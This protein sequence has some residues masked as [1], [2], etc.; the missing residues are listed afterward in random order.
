MVEGYLC[1]FLTGAF[2]TTLAPA[3]A[4]RFVV[5][6]ATAASTAARTRTKMPDLLYLMDL[7]LFFEQ[8]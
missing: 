5:D 6:V 3:P 1:P 8:Y 7:N 4:I 2:Y